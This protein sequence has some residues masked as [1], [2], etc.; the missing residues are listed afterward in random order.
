MIMRLPLMLLLA[1][2]VLAGC[3]TAPRRQ[4]G[5]V[6]RQKSSAPPTTLWYVG[7]VN[8]VI[9]GRVPEEAPKRWIDADSFLLGFE[10]GS[11]EGIGGLG[12]FLAVNGTAY[13]KSTDMLSP[14]YYQVASG[15]RFVT[16]GAVFLPRGSKPALTAS[17]D[18]STTTTMA[19]LYD[20]LYRAAGNR[21][22]VV[23]GFVEWDTLDTL[24]VSQAPIF[25][26]DLFKNKARYYGFGPQKRAT[27]STYLV[28]CAAN[29]AAET[30]SKRREP[31]GRILY[32][33]PFDT[34]KGLATHAHVLVLNEANANSSGTIDPPEVADVCHLLSQ[35]VV[36]RAELGV[37]PI[38]RL[39]PLQVALVSKR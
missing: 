18:G 7:D 22:F 32:N 29:F 27:V 4:G 20:D 15:P 1:L 38:D 21:A 26:E 8:D 25:G 3:A 28:G 19:M 13:A 23:A 10:A 35:S 34:G 30:D 31:L 37:Y 39:E 24:S 5:L 9:A 33:N 2:L 17:L 11:P 16:T 36:R 6:V 14:H 12:E